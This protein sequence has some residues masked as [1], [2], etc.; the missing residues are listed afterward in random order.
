MGPITTTYPV[1]GEERCLK[2]TVPQ[3]HLSPLFIFND[4]LRFFND[5]LT[6]SAIL[7]HHTGLPSMDEKPKDFEAFMQYK[8]TYITHKPL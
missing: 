1:S 2:G 3:D 6:K 7:Y 4:Q 8:L 5:R